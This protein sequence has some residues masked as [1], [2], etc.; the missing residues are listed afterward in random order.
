MKTAFLVAVIVA[1]VAAAA[2]AMVS[3]EPA[4]SPYTVEISDVAG[5]R[6]LTVTPEVVAAAPGFLV[7]PEVVT[8]AN[9]MPEVVVRGAP[10][11]ARGQ[12]LGARG[13]NLGQPGREE[14]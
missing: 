9:Q 8:R 12:M 11:E 13:K 4:P 7:M 2:W 14:V 10:D 1:L 6:A 3:S 5:V